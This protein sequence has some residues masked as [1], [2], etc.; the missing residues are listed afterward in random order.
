MARPR[1]RS[2]R[3]AAGKAPAW[4]PTTRGP[5]TPHSGWGRPTRLQFGRKIWSCRH[6]SFRTSAAS[7]HRHSFSR[8]KQ[9]QNRRAWSGTAGAARL[10]RAGRAPARPRREAPHA[11]PARCP[12]APAIT[13][14]GGSFATIWGIATACV[15][16]RGVSLAPKTGPQAKV[17]NGAVLQADGG[18]RR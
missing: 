10:G 12:A 16:E 4:S 11:Q 14:S 7:A 13:Q 3:R 1:M 6:L 2:W 18:G 5:K 9:E 8:E 17:Y 15:R